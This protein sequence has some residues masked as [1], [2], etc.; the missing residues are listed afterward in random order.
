MDEKQHQA[1]IERLTDQGF[2]TE[3]QSMPAEGVI[4]D[5]MVLT[6]KGQR[7]M[8]DITDADKRR[9]YENAAN[10]LSAS[11]GFHLTQGCYFVSRWLDRCIGGWAED[12][13][14][15]EVWRDVRPATFL[16]GSSISIAEQIKT[17]KA[18]YWVDIGTA[19][20][21]DWDEGL[22]LAGR[23]EQHYKESIHGNTNS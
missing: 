3:G 8:E 2:V 12:M 13:L 19:L 16:I 9:Q 14:R 11:F 18:T 20:A 15:V 10:A 4:V 22:V 1:S 7:F 21:R 5:D 6:E 17:I 23:F